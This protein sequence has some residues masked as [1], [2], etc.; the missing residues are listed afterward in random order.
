[1]IV[2]YIKAG[3]SCPISHDHVRMVLSMLCLVEGYSLIDD[4]NTR[5]SVLEL[6]NR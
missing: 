5:L 3:I 6:A 1:M 2:L 4:T